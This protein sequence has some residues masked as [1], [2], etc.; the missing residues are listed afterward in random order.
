V[1]QVR[2]AAAKELERTLGDSWNHA[3]FE[4][5]RT[6]IEQQLA[7]GQL[8]EALEGAQA[9]LQ[10]TQSA[11]EQAYANADYALAV[12]F[13]LLG[14]VLLM[15]GGADQALPL[16]IDA[17]QRFEAVAKERPGRGAERM[18]S[19]CLAEQ[20][21]CLFSLGR[22]DEAAAAY[23]EN[24]QRAEQ[25]EDSRQVA[26]GKGQL[27]SVRLQQ[28]RYPEALAAYAEARQ[29]FTALDE[30]GTVAV[31][32]HQTGRVYQDAGQPQAAED[33]YRKS[34]AIKVRLGDVAGQ[35][36]TLNQLGNLY[37]YLLDRPEDAAG[38]YRQ[39][40]VKFVEGG[41]AASEGLARNN[42]AD[43]L[44]KLRRL[45]EARQEI[46][47]AIDCKA[48]FGLASEP[49]K[50][51]AILAAIETDSGNAAAAAEAK[52]KALAYYL[53]YRRD[54]GEN[55]NIDGRISLAVT[56]ALRGGDPAQAAT[57][58]QQLAAAPEAAGH[59]PFIGALQAVVAGSRDPALAEQP[60]LDYTMAA[61]IL[62]LI[63]T[64][65]G[66]QG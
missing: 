3:R 21:D 59:L 24:I 26:V 39:A 65:A 28:R 9:L 54:G 32:W 51:W 41:D 30:P 1:G 12:A 43:T 40:A 5:T 14:R 56:Q 16:L 60:G 44:R 49:W 50:S 18:A 8:R 42:L 34:L 46:L 36:G 29:R 52:G 2:D 35:A 6:R 7:G 62:L 47:Q 25:I 55:H 66:D 13:L 48:R 19:V 38:F 61:E 37:G 17:R 22:F 63:E 23:E 58:L 53:A 15:A 45:D 31:S 64:L 33:A 10:R 11:G 4:A 20:G 27:G 57:L